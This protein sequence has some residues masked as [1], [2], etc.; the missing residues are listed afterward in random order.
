L[1]EEY[2]LSVFEKRILRKILRP[3]KEEDRSWRKV[4]N[5]ELHNMYSSPNIVRGIKLRRMGWVEY[6]AHMGEGRGVYRVL[7]ARPKGKRPLER[8]RCRWEDKIKMDRET[9][10]NGANWTQLTQDRVQWWAF[11][12]MVMN[13]QVP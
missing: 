2:K 13:L 5:N 3:K 11:V 4:H 7:V 9:G 1:G 10:I 8:P 6:V 12:S